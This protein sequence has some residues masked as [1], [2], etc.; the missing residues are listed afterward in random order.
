M[1]IK[2]KQKANVNNQKEINVSAENLSQNGRRGKKDRNQTKLSFIV[3]LSL[4]ELP[5][6][7]KASLV[8]VLVR[9]N[10]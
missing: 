5:L 2:G 1:Q 3:A 9:T 8:A 7:R 10:V 6:S 4:Y